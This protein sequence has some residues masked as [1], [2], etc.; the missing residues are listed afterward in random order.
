MV[1]DGRY[2]EAAYAAVAEEF[3]SIDGYLRDGLELGAATLARLR[4]RMLG[5]PAD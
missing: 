4:D 5:G 1:A 2:L 3:G